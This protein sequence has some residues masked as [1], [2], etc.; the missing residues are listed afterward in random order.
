MDLEQLQADFR[1]HFTS[2]RCA[3]LKKATHEAYSR[4]MSRHSL[5][6][7]DDAQSFG[8]INY[9]YIAKRMVGLCDGPQ[10]F[11]LRKAHPNIR[12][13]VGPFTV[14]AYC[15]GSTGDQDISESFPLNE[16]GAP[17]LVDLNQDLTQ[18]CAELEDEPLVPR[19]V[20]LAHLGNYV[21]GLEALYLAVPAAKSRKRIAGWCH[22]ELLWKRNAGEE[23]GDTPPDLPRP[24]V[25]PPAPLSLKL[26]PDRSAGSEK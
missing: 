26:Q 18:F 1:T 16:N 17:Q 2:E 23:G 19:A 20:V 7:G 15:C 14:A 12:I 25:I 8:F 6:D 4:A 21:T 9:K 3:S 22:T 24:V 11:E 5:D 13:G 10:G